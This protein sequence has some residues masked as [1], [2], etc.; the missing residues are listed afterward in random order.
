[1][2]GSD[3]E[4][5]PARLLVPRHPR[6]RW[7][8]AA[9][10][11]VL[12]LVLGFALVWGSREQIADN[13]IGSQLAKNGL[14]A[15]YEVQRIGPRRQI[16][17]NVVI[18]NPARPDLT[19]E[20][21]QVA[22][23]YRFGFPAI[24][25]IVAIKPRLYGSYRGG[26][27]SFGTLDK[28]L[29]EG[30]DPD[31]PFRLPDLDVAVVDGRGLLDSEWGP[32]GVKV[33]GAGKLRNGF[34]GTLAA[35]APQA[36]VA[37]CEVTRASLYGAATVRAERLRFN[38]PVRL[39]A[40]A[41]PN[42]TR[43][44]N[45]GLQVEATLDKGFDGG[46]A[47]LGLE[48][49]KAAL[50]DAAARSLKG[51]VKATFRG[52]GLTARYD[53]AAVGANA[54]SL[55]GGVLSTEGTL[56][57]QNGLGR[58][59][60]EGSLAG[61]NIAL[62]NGL[63][64]GLAGLEKATAATM[65]G[66]MIGQMRAA[67]RREAPGSRLAAD[68]RA[69]FAEGTSNLVVP[70]AS[71]R[72]R[73]GATL[74]ALSRFQAN[75]AGGRAPLLSGNIVTGGPGLP[76]IAGRMERP[77]AGAAVFRLS[78][79]EYRAGSGSLAV[80]TLV[81]AQT[82]DGALGFV[83]EMRVSGPLPGGMARNLAAPL[84]GNWSPRG[85]LALWRRCARVGFDALS[86]ANLSLDRRSL[87]LC[88]PPG[89]AIVRSSSAGTRFAAGTSNLDVVGR[90][91]ST[92]IRIQAASAG[93]AAPGRLEARGLAVAL[94]P[95]AR[96]S[97]FNVGHLS[98]NVGKAIVGRFEQTEMRLHA[99]PMDVLDANGTWSYAD[100]A[101][102]ISGA[103]FELVDRRAD[104]R[105]QPLEGRSGTV[106]LRGNSL[107]ATASLDEPRSGR[108]VTRADIRHDL[109]TGR[110]HAN[111]TTT[112]L[113]FDSALQPSSVSRLFLGAVANVRGTIRGTGRIEWNNRATTSTGQ[114]STDALD[115]AA[116]FGPVKGASGTV[117]FTD[118][119][120]LVTAPNQ[121]FHV[122]SM[123]P[124][125]E[126]ENGIV[127]LEL[128]R[129]NVLAIN[130][131]TWPFMGGT[132]TLQPTSLNMGVSETRRYTLRVD[133]L[134][135]GVFVKEMG[136]DEVTASGIF[137]GVIPLVFDENGGRVIGGLLNSRPPGGNVAYTG[138]LTKKDLSTMANFAFDALKSLDYRS[139]RI[140]MDGRL[141]GELVTRVTMTSVRQGPG[142]EQN[143]ITKRIAR[144]PLQFSINVRGPFY[145][146][147]RS[148]KS[149][150]DPAF[151]RS[152]I[153]LG[154]LD[155]QGRPINMEVVNPPPPGDKPPPVPP[156]VRPRNIQ[157]PDSR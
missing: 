110:G 147:I 65:L 108:E 88:P 16:L 112:G 6:R 70:Q 111:L 105:F 57:T 72:G 80:P 44:A 12:L 100:K 35:I 81:V 2:D 93:F 67:L 85:G 146:L 133:G 89:G 39:S 116:G 23:R 127:E 155:S 84:D 130:S 132:L 60:L 61:T 40:L 25:R 152:P 98:A 128:R 82:S 140:A 120:G 103:A 96:A 33:V 122:R 125:I 76:Q 3:T 66:P 4:I 56:R 138:Q 64:G 74:V 136:L 91:G 143:F 124:G 46:E 153:A 48:T 144:L 87:V 154:L 21:M 22:I 37:G 113:A 95:S 90:L 123:N 42:G 43:L 59:E 41:C 101:L 156:S 1:M 102:K 129:G 104:A 38:G 117:V 150:K 31:K 11:V 126:V 54:Q 20:Q 142:A 99:V 137:D 7:R 47:T 51:T 50:A 19:I 62:G 106:T 32:I 26:K 13:Y 148:V 34:S 83:G 107:V 121:K 118:L 141:T 52:N 24:G 45:A 79:A 69:R 5:E 15:T 63:D 86:Y 9:G 73:S 30:G 68:Y 36:V 18:G 115:F 49:G 119:L 78:M 97:R 149:F 17:R 77:A 75:W 92:P 28:V 58:M 14:T 151:T 71:L 29:F 94:G 134:D 27:L 139:M 135:A 131:A 109:A 114:F 55:A 145:Q 10:L 157:R 8:L 53:L